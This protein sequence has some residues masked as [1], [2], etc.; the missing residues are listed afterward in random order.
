MRYSRL[1][2]K[3]LRKT[4]KQ[5]RSKGYALL[6]QGGFVRPVAR[7]LYA[8]LPMGMR[9][10]E[11]IKSIIREELAVLEGQ[12]MRI[13]MVNPYGIWKKGGRLELIGKELVRFKDRDGRNLVLAPSHEE[14][15]VEIARTTL[16]SYRD[17]PIFLY[18][19]QDK[20]RDE[21]KCKY[22]LV[23]T[24]E[25]LMKDAYS[26]HRSYTNLNNFFPKVYSAYQKI[27]ERVGVDII[28]AEAGV[29][30][31][32][33]EKSY[34]FLTPSSYGD[35]VVI[36]C[37]E[38]G[39]ASN[40][41]I[42]VGIK[43]YNSEVPKTLE[44][45]STP[46]CTTME[47]L[48]E[49]LKLPRAKL[50][51]AMVYKTSPGYAMALVRGDYDVSVEKLSRFLNRPVLRKATDRE[52]AVNGLLPG[53]LSPIN[54][55]GEMDIVVDETVANSSNLV[56][57]TNEEGCHYINVNFGRD[58]ESEYV[59]DISRIKKDNY[60]IQCGH[61][62]VETKAM[63]LGNIFKLGQFY[64][65]RMNLVIDDE[66][67]NGIFPYMGAYGIGMGRLMVA[68]VDA[69]HDDRGISWPPRLAPYKA[70]LMGIGR[71]F[72]VQRMVEQIHEDH[73]NEILLDD[74]E[75]SPGVKFKDADLI[76]L[77]LR[78]VVSAKNLQEGK[79]EFH[80]RNS[81]ETWLVATD[82]IQE[83]LKIWKQ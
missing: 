41:E 33:G 81:D 65:K 4:P 23:R 27:F 25:F 69:N 6:H 60:C 10:I 68:V 83:V 66:K 7:G 47:E 39:Y 22:G 55:D 43:E 67:G 16:K 54:F 21:E 15:I 62:L 72:R 58:F 9:V 17:L 45:V 48:S 59:A 2:G 20:F 63:E 24:K 1:L 46:G 8:Y 3:T 74:R 30:Y 77:P 11:N 51:K 37:S 73:G 57:G 53:Y 71:S 82:K 64:T 80:D 49:L 52:L 35:D 76:G 40:R 79:V 36:Q 50:G 18:E 14:A 31:I 70:F 13:P 28:T 32:G 29:G 78:I 34:E 42:A 26:F 56:L 12:E 19:F 44:V 38:C 61:I 5:V 75:E